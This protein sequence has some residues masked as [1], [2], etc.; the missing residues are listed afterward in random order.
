MGREKFRNE[1]RKFP[2]RIYFKNSDEKIQKGSFFLNG[3]LAFR[4]FF[5]FFHKMKFQI[6]QKNEPHTGRSDLLT[7]TDETFE[8]FLKKVPFKRKEDGTLVAEVWKLQDI[9]YSFRE[10]F[11]EKKMIFDLVDEDHVLFDVTII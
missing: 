9:V 5:Q 2:K 10:I 1:I 7:I 11:P 8:F 3:I 4:N 6:F